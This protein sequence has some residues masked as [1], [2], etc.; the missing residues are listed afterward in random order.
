M[1]LTETVYDLTYEIWM[2]KQTKD[3]QESKRALVHS[4]G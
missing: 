1:G 4:L 2:E 3:F